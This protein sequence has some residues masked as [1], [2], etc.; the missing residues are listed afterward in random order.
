V[1]N[2][3][4]TLRSRLT[5]LVIV[6]IFG[7]VTIVTGSSIQREVAQYDAGQAAELTASANVFAVAVA[8]HVRDGKKDL[9]LDALKA[10]S[11]LPTVTY[12]R[13]E[14]GDGSTFVELGGDVAL[15]GSSAAVG[16]ASGRAL[17]MFRVKTAIV[18]SPIIESG[19]TVGWLQLNAD[20]STLSARLS[21]LIWDAFVAAIFAAGI[22]LLVA[23]RMQRV[24]TRP[25][26]ALSQVMSE[27][28]KTG[29]FARRATRESDDEIG[30]LADSFNDMLDQVQERD[31]RLL[32]HQTDL[33]N[34]VKRRTQELEKA[35]EVAERAS[36]TKS[37]FLATMSHEIRTPM[38]GMLVM[39]E[40]LNNADLPPRQ[41]RYAHVIVKSGQSLLAI[42]NDILDFSKIEAGR[43]DL[44]QIPV[45]PV[46]V[47]ND[48]V[49]L[50]WERASSKNIDLAAYVGPNVP[51]MIEAD[52]VRLNQVLSN[53][54]NN[55][56][57]FTETGHVLVSARRIHSPNGRCVIEFSVTDTG[58]GIAKDKQGGIFEAFSQADQSTTRKFGGT[59]L[60][61]AICRR[62]VEAMGGTL[63]V[64]SREGAGSRFFFSFPTKVVEPARTPIEALSGDKRA[65]IAIGGSATPKMLARYLEE[66]GISAQIVD[67]ESAIVSHMAYA[68][69]IFAAPEFLDAFHAAVEGAPEHWV[70]ARIC[71]SDLGD[72]AP[73][74]LLEAGIAE[75]LLI[76]PLSRHDVVA[77]I[78]RILTG[79]L[80]RSDAVRMVAAKAGDL[81]SFV[82]ARVLAA[83]DS[84]VNREVVKEA[85]SRLGIEAVLVNDGRAAVKAASQ[86]EF[87]L[88]LMDCSM[89]DMDGYEATQAIRARERERGAR[90]VP[91]IALTAHVAGD[92]EKWR[93]AGMND[94]LTKPFTIKTLASA[95]ASFVPPR[96]AAR[97]ATVVHQHEP[98]AATAAAIEAPAPNEPF[99]FGALDA[100]A[101]MQSSGDLVVRA[102][103]LFEQHSKPAVVK[104]AQAVR[105]GEA[106]TIKSAAHALKSM[107][108]NVGAIALGAICGRIESLAAQGAPAPAVATALIEARDAFAAAHQALPSLL[109][110]YARRAA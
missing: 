82:G 24:V 12:A 28:R 73:D 108:V 7:S 68:D 49:G 102:L 26:I 70:P 19:A 21:A 23:L 75:D 38:N 105:T 72:A 103:K 46:E 109:D 20:T 36:K 96:R 52:P 29:D 3:S 85:L 66:S 27:V 22:G 53:L 106:A 59:G 42:I 10:I 43:L 30:G 32:A 45:S 16:A 18:R 63:G 90:A 2:N 64:S 71:V 74:R 51:E 50:F 48:V 65:I 41:K 91:I 101:E 80:R 69:I 13:V 56:L 57:K 79:R 84:A 5:T 37:E 89:P 35:K 55:A 92:A 11:R 15:D 76:K 104:L 60:G 97:G 99:S 78:E 54:T 67:R 93:S 98:A 100:L 34:I 87:D 86:A 110:R 81:P 94:Y 33:K 25:I 17:S 107:S 77:Q 6:A 44:E 31:R 4:Q 83:D 88:I 62:L 8:E 61:L 58:V 14:L 95:I 39:A 1:R 47:I 40:L 9:T